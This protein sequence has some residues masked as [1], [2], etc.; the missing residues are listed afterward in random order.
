MHFSNWFFSKVSKLRKG[1]KSFKLLLAKTDHK[2]TYIRQKMLGEV[3]DYYELIIFSSQSV[4]NI[5]E[6]I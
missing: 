2:K 6:S 5:F 3:A 1:K 4:Y